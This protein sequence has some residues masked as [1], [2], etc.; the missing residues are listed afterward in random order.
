MLTK[1]KLKSICHIQNGI[2]KLTEFRFRRCMRQRWAS[3]VRKI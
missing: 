2:D 3:A 1:A